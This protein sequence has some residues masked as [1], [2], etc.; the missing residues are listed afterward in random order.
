MYHHIYKEVNCALYQKDII[1]VCTSVDK[2]GCYFCFFCVMFSSLFSNIS[3]KTVIITPTISI[4][5]KWL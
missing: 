3:P 4:I 2:C 1:I 5:S